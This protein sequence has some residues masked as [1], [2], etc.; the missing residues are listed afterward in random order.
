MP[1]GFEPSREIPWF[2]R[3]LPQTTQPRH[4]SNIIHKLSHFGKN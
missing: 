3:P 1:E 4:H 2:S